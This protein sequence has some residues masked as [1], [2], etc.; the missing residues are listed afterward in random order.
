MLKIKQLLLILI[1]LLTFTLIG[2]CAWLAGWDY[3]IEIALPDYAGDIGAEV[4]WFPVTVFL[5]ATQ[6]EEV[7]VEFTTEA[8]YLKVAFTDSSGDTE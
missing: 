5:T 7:F 6:C 1:F 2:N 4:V 8:E 3:R